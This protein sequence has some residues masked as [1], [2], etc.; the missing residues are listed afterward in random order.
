MSTKKKV[1]K[2]ASKTKVERATLVMERL[3][4]K[5]WEGECER[6]DI[7]KKLMKD[8]DMSKAYAATAYQTIKSRMIE[9][10][11]N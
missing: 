8:C 9:D 3:M 6:K 11:M 2:K 7:I 1:T 4:P 5:Y 10:E